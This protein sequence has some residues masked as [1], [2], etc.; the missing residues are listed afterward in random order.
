MVFLVNATLVIA[1]IIVF[2]IIIFLLVGLLLAAKAKLAPSG[3]VT[4]EINGE[5]REVDSGH[6]LLTTLSLS[7]G[8]AS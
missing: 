6:T 7:L 4:L 3:P 2:F 5:E 8:R 1:S